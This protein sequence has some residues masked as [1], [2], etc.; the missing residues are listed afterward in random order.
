[1]WGGGGGVCVFVCV[2][3]SLSLSLSF[4]LS[5][6]VCVC[7]CVCLCVREGV[8]ACAC[9]CVCV[10]VCVLLKC[11]DD[12]AY[13]F[14][15]NPPHT[16]MVD[17]LSYLLFQPVIHDWCNTGRSMCYPVSGMVHITDPLLLITKSIHVLATTCLSSIFTICRT[18]E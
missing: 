8:R 15:G 1:M 3:L 12:L 18:N 14:K 2:C 10:C 16:F 9:V 4:S 5:L 11:L 17:P 6:S 13:I 7:V